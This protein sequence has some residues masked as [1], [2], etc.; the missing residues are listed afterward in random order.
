MAIRKQKE[1]PVY[2]ERQ[3]QIEVKAHIDIE[4]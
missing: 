1:L 4:G 3:V 2:L